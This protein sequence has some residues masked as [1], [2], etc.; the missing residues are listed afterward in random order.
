MMTVDQAPLSYRG[1]ASGREPLTRSGPAAT[2][3]TVAIIGGGVAGLAAAVAFQR[4]GFRA[5]VYER[6]PSYEPAGQGFLLMPNGLAALDR[7]GLG[8]AVRAVGCSVDRACLRAQDGEVLGDQPLPEMCCVPRAELL[9]I[10]RRPLR[11]GAVRTGMDLDGFEPGAPG[12]P[13]RARFRNG[14]TI[15]AD[16]FVGADGVRSGVRRALFPGQC[17]LTP[18]RV[19]EL[20]CMMRCPAIADRLGSTLMKTQ[21]DEGGLAMGLVPAGRGRLIWYLQFD[22]ERWC[23]GDGAEEKRRFMEERV[24]QWLDPIPAVL[25]RTDFSSVYVRRPV[26]MAMPPSF[27]RGNAVLI[28]DAAHTV[29]PF[30]SQGANT[31][32]EDAVILADCL[33]RGAEAAPASAGEGSSS[34]LL[35]RAL[36]RFDASRRES[37]RRCLLEGREMAHRFV[38]PGSLGRS[39]PLTFVK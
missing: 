15:T 37:L 4:R 35:P 2:S 10:L 39:L 1:V 32:L 36:A 30:T 23:V 22:A 25:A 12:A 6:A 26:D 14:E 17:V 19:H 11:S 7:L 5:R 38:L 8:D 28:G 21:S 16:L 3:P 29:L 27:A 24:G 18:S 13:G 31:A 9:E 34:T 33:A 20:V